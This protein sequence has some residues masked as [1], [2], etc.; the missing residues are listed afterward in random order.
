MRCAGGTLGQLRSANLEA[1]FL[2]IMAAL[3]TMDDAAVSVSI[4]AWCP[5]FRPRGRPPSRRPRRVPGLRSG[6]SSDP[7]PRRDGASAHPGVLWSAGPRAV[8]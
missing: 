6:R 5:K 8:T 1:P 7:H 4:S 2:A 3:F